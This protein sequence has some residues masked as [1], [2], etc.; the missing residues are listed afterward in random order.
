MSNHSSRRSP[1]PEKLAKFNFDRLEKPL[2][3][4][5]KV[6]NRQQSEELGKID[7]SDDEGVQ[8]NENLPHTKTIVH[9]ETLQKNSL[10]I[11]H[12]PLEEDFLD[13]LREMAKVK[14]EKNHLGHL[15]VIGSEQQV[16]LARFLIQE[17]VRY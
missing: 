4:K 7:E 1:S 2:K 3:H 14:V 13:E 17:E 8:K 16:A 6:I 15:N 10:M 12:N 5:T 9:F 11:L